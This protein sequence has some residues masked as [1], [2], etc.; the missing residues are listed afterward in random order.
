MKYIFLKIKQQKG[1]SLLELLIAVSI[2]TVAFVALTAVAQQNIQTENIN[3]NSLTASLLAQECLEIVRNQRDNNWSNDL[4]FSHNLVGE[5]D[6][7]YL[8]NRSEDLTKL[9]INSDGHYAHSGDEES[10][11]SRKITSYLFG[12]DYLDIKCVV[13]WK[14]RGRD[15]EYAVA[16]KLYDWKYIPI[17]SEEDED[18]EEEGGDEE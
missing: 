10:I 9:Y 3:K 18:G 12:D 15:K 4:D 2:I 17:I 13:I 7:D 5:F 1:F 6:F 14:E 16:M 11:F 8:G